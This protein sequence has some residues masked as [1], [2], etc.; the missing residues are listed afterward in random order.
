MVAVRNAT[1]IA[2]GRSA[3]AKASTFEEMSIATP[4]KNGIIPRLADEL[5]QVITAPDGLS[6]SVYLNYIEVYMGYV[7]DLLDY[8][9][10]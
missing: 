9:P 10:L 8:T 2:D 7:W 3:S 1:I 5:F 4:S 6:F